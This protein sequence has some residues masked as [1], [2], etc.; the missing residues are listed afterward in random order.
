MNAE[1]M[2]INPNELV[3]DLPVDDAHVQE[4]M[5]SLQKNGRMVEPVT[6]WLQG[7]RIINGF[8]RTE[9][10]KRLGWESMPC[11]IQD[12]TE[13]EFWDARI[14]AAKPHKAVEPARMAAWM[15]ESWRNS[16]PDNVITLEQVKASCEQ[17]G[18]TFDKAKYTV[19][20]RSAMCLFDALRKYEPED[21]YHRKVKTETIKVQYGTS[22]NG[23]RL[24]KNEDVWSKRDATT[25]E[26]WFEHKAQQWGITVDDIKER[27]ELSTKQIIGVRYSDYGVYYG[28]NIVDEFV[29]HDVARRDGTVDYTW[30]S[31]IIAGKCTAHDHQKYI[32]QAIHRSE[33]YEQEC[34]RKQEQAIA[35]EFERQSKRQQ[36]IEDFNRRLVHGPSHKDRWRELNS[37]FQSAKLNLML[38]QEVENIPEAPAMLAEFAQF[39]ADF[40]AEHFPDV[41]VA[42]PNPVSLE[43]SRLRAENARLKERIASLER[44]LGSK[45]A[46][47]EMLSSAMA[48]SSGDIER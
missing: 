43:N 22:K 8:H 28:R 44:A 35:E 14:I 24:F 9:A 6:V 18:V 1:T 4:L 25:L 12:L 33:V 29:L 45:Q 5:N 23:R 21:K 7:M 31:D 16:F 39:V 3:I 15:L 32:Q 19:E 36:E 38:T 42:Q 27:L 17:W 41:Q 30:V 10:A 47:G 11:L 48:W 13:D 46:A 20:Y 40:S 26:M 2:T 37:I 34:Q